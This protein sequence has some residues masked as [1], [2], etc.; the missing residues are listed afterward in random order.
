[1]TTYS[2]QWGADT[3]E[4]RADF[5]QASC[6]VHGTNGR[7]VG[8]FGHRPASAMRYAIEHEARAEGLDPEDEDVA[9]Q[10]DNAVEDMEEI[11]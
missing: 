11:D 3:I 6:P 1:M 5:S 8:D 2:T 7:Q 9:E 10:I 4:I